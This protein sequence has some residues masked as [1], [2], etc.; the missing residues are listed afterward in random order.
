MSNQ[1]GLPIGCL[2]ALG[3]G[4]GIAGTFVFL[5]VLLLGSL[6]SIGSEDAVYGK[7]V[8]RIDVEGMITSTSSSSWTGSGESMVD[9][10]AKQLKKAKEDEDA[11]AVVIRINSPGGEVTA[12][13]TLYHHVSQLAK[14]KPV[15]VYM[16]SM[17]ASGGYYIACGAQE[18]YA[19]QT[20]LTGSIG[21][22]ISTM[23]Y[24][25]LIDKVGLRFEVFTSGKFKDTLSGSRSMREDEKAL[26]QDMVSQIYERFLEVVMQSRS[27]I[28]EA[29]LRTQLA[30]GRILTGSDASESGLIDGTGYIE[31]VYD[32]ARQLGNAPDVPVVKY[33]EEVSIIGALGLMQAKALAGGGDTKVELHLPESLVPDLQPG[34]VYLLPSFFAQ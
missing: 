5:F 19:N 22:I 7:H 2:I 8:A 26:I 23:N 32:R 33:S 21:V 31:D 27:D 9:R 25:D 34:R 20:T 17:A 24:A 12:A 29:K 14:E 30:D 3:V 4:I 11:V 1:R 18:I 10:I 13:D 28:P 6:G 16:D 15:L